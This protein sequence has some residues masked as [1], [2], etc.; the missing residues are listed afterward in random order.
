MGSSKA[1]SR[2]LRCHGGGPG[3]PDRRAVGTTAQPRSSSGLVVRL[4]QAGHQRV[5]IIVGHPA[6]HHAGAARGDPQQVRGPVFSL[7][8]QDHLLAGC[9][10]RLHDAPEWGIVLL[11]FFVRTAI[12]LNWLRCTAIWLPYK[13]TKKRRATKRIS[14]RRLRLQED[15][16]PTSTSP[17]SAT[18]ALT[19]GLW[20]RRVFDLP[21]SDE[22]EKE[23]AYWAYWPHHGRPSSSASS[24]P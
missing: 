21:S 13:Q 9:R 23:E 14:R 8:G 6:A 4:S 20:K 3:V 17:R 10:R 22:F 5:V 2:L 24:P 19:T 7:C 11:D 16:T 1:E 15:P 12:L 18:S